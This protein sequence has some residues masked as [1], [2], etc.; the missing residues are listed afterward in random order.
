MSAS[1]RPLTLDVNGVP[2][3][4]AATD[5][6][7]DALVALWSTERLLRG[8]ATSLPAPPTIDATGLATAIWY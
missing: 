2:R 7:L 6:V 4:Q 8:D 1:E 3:R 5:D